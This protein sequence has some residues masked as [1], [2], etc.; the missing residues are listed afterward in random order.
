MGSA[1]ARGR[2]F[3][4]GF[5]ARVRVRYQSGRLQW[6]RW[7]DQAKG[8]GDATARRLARNRKKRTKYQRR[9]LKFIGLLYYCKPTDQEK[10]LLDIVRHASR[11][12][13][14]YREQ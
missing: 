8:H 5:V 7:G 10:Y 2:G 6:L 12:S 14:L 4:A 1:A 3:S 13:F 11:H 9:P